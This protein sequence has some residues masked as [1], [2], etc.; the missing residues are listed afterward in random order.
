MREAQ[1]SGLHLLRETRA[2]AC[3]HVVGDF[4]A[5]DETV[6]ADSL[7]QQAKPH[8]AAETDV[9]CVAARRNFG[10]FYGGLDR[11]AMA[12]VEHDRHTAPEQSMGAAELPGHRG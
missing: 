10:R 6:V 11:A 12:A 7:Q 8:A 3:E 4:H 2:G 9:G 5:L 1:P